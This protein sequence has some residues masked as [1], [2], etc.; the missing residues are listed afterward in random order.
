[1][2]MPFGGPFERPLCA[3]AVRGEGTHTVRSVAHDIAAGRSTCFA[4]W[5]AADAS[6]PEDS[7]SPLMTPESAVLPGTRLLE[8]SGS[9]QPASLWSGELDSATGRSTSPTAWATADDGPA[10][11]RLSRVASPELAL[12]PSLGDR[13]TPGQPSTS[14][15]LAHDNPAGCASPVA[16]CIAAETGTWDSM[17]RLSTPETLSAACINERPAAG[18]PESQSG[19]WQHAHSPSQEE[20]DG[21]ALSASLP[22]AEMACTDQQDR[23]QLGTTLTVEQ[24]HGSAV[25]ASPPQARAACMASIE[26]PAAPGSITAA[27]P[28]PVRESAASQG[29]ASG[30][31]APCMAPAPVQGLRAYR[32]AQAV[33]PGQHGL[34]TQSVSRTQLETTGRD[35]STPSPPSMPSPSAHHHSQSM[36]PESGGHISAAWSAPAQQSPD[37]RGSRQGAYSS[38]QAARLVVGEAPECYSPALS[39]RGWDGSVGMAFTA[40]QHATVMLWLRRLQTATPLIRRL[41]FR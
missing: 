34:H 25:S 11:C 19:A 16:A 20:P 21:R 5:A 22:P 37:V 10:T 26:A 13:L 9:A 1:M 28:A 33:R 6:L 3:A 4:A 41:R 40:W 2:A 8:C 12:L 15:S 30:C 23:R 7:L 14:G 18:D 31:E 32:G 35:N 36:A 24:P 17:C 27:A 38:L 29:T 39:L